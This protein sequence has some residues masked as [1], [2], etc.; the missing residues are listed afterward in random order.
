MAIRVAL[1]DLQ[2]GW[3]GGVRYLLSLQK[4]IE[5]LEQQGVVEVVRHPRFHL[6]E[7]L[8]RKR[9]GLLNA[10]TYSFDTIRGVNALNL[11]RPLGVLSKRSLAWI[12]DLQDIERPEFFSAEEILRRSNLRKNYLRKDRAFVFSSNHALKV[13]N[14]IGYTHP[15]IAG[16][17][18]FTSIFESV[19]EDRDSNQTC[20]GCKENGYF[21]LPNQWWVHKNHP[22]AVESFTEYQKLGGK[23]HLVLTG[24]E[25]DTRWP[26]YSAHKVFSKFNVK[27]VHR[28]GLVSRSLQREL[29]NETLAV[30]QP[31]SY[32]GW[33]TTIEEA[34]TLGAPVIASDIPSN[35]EQLENRADSVLISLKSNIDFVEALFSPPKKLKKMEFEGLAIRRWERFLNDL[36]SV[37]Q[38]GEKLT[39]ASRSLRKS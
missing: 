31:S 39:N 9:Y 17:L 11:P 25:G 6:N 10:L 2:P 24:T 27:N 38:I 36:E 8:A 7:N 13:F 4:A 29:Y 22:W 14:S 18:R 23:A 26:D 28:L 34:F 37:I 12:P 35:R 19:F 16:T 3:V 1:P 21:Y 33:S 32:E 30:I 5:A 15:L 20:A